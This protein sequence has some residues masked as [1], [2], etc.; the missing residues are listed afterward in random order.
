MHETAVAQA[1]FAFDS[2][3]AV[4]LAGFAFDSSAAVAQAV[5]NSRSGVFSKQR[6]QSFI[7][8]G[9][10]GPGSGAMSPRRS[11]PKLGINVSLKPNRRL[12]AGYHLISRLDRRGRSIEN[13]NS[14]LSPFFNTY[15]QPELRAKNLSSS[16]KGFFQHNRNTFWRSSE[17]KRCN[18]RKNFLPIITGSDFMYQAKMSSSEELWDDPFAALHEPFAGLKEMDFDLHG[19]YMDH[20]PD[21]NSSPH[22]INVRTRQVFPSNDLVSEEEEEERLEPTYRI[23]DP[24]TL[25]YKMKPKLGDVFESPEQLKF[26]V[27]NYV[28]ARGYEIFFGKSDS[29]KVVSKCGSRKEGS[30]CPFILHAGW[31]Y[32]ERSLQIKTMNDTHNCARTFKFC[33]TPKSIG[34]NI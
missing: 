26:C 23:H 1:G 6:S 3:A 13:I 29:V 32:R 2:S 21:D 15:Y 18:Q 24:N 8:R 25:W 10:G 30:S 22:S 33:H 4:A 17:L 5:I 11:R 34:R 27:A 16:S 9:T 14:R 12:A 20:E 19:I 31:M 28:V 7:D